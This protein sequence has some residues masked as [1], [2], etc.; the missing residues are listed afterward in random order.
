M[1]VGRWAAL[2]ALF[3]AACDRSPQGSP[4]VAAVRVETG[5]KASCLR[6]EALDER[7]TVLSTVD[8]EPFDKEEYKVAIYQGELPHQIG[9][10]ALAMWGEGCAEPLLSNGSSTT[11]RSTFPVGDP[12]TVTLTLAAP[13]ATFDVDRDGFISAGAGGPDC[14]DQSS[15]V[16]PSVREYC[17]GVT[18]LNCDGKA[19]CADPTCQNQPCVQPASQ[20]AFATTAQTVAAGACSNEVAVE[21]RDPSGTVTPVTAVT[22][23]ALS[24]PGGFTFYSDPSCAF[25]TTSV[26]LPLNGSRAVFRFRATVPGT[27]PLTATT[28]ALGS[29]TQNATVRAGSASALAFVTPA[30]TVAA[31]ACSEALTL[32]ARD[33]SGNPSPVG[34]D[35]PLTLTANPP[36]GV[37]FFADATCGL[38]AA[39]LAIPAG[40]TRATFHFR[41]TTPGAV[42]VASS[43]AGL[44]TV[45]QVQ[46]VT[47]GAPAAIV[48]V[49]PQRTAVS[50]A[51]SP[52]VTVETRDLV[53]NVAPV[54]ANTSIALSAT[55]TGSFS[56][57][58]DAA[59]TVGIAAVTLSAGQSQGSFHFRATT[60]G[61]GNL[62]TSA[63]GLTGATQP[64]TILPG[65]PAKIGFATPSQGVQSN[66]C[67]GVVTIEAQDAA[68][69]RSNLATGSMVALS[70][71]PST[72]FAFFTDPGCTTP[73]MNVTILAGAASVNFYFRGFNTGP[74]NV[75][76]QTV[77]LGFATQQH[78]IVLGPPTRLAFV[79]GPKTLVAGACS[80]V[81]S[82]QTQDA[83]GNP[84][85]V[86]AP[87]PLTLGASPAA[88]FGFF[89]DASCTT[90][91]TGITLSSG[92][93]SA[94]FYVRGTQPGA[95]GVTVSG[96]GLS[97]A[98]QTETIQAG[99]PVALV[100]ATPSQTV[101][102]GNCSG[103]AT[104]R[105]TDAFNNP[106]PVTTSTSVALT[107]T[108]ASGFAFF[109]DAGCTAP[110]SSVTLGVGTSS[111]SFYFRGTTAGSVNITAS[112][113][114]GS[115]SQLETVAAGNAAAL[116]FTTAAQTLSAGTCSGNVT[117]QRQDS[118][119]N[120]TT[121]GGTLTVSLLAAP[122]AGFTF[123]RNGSCSDGPFTSVT[124]NAGSTGTSFRFLGNVAGSVT[125]TA[126]ASGLSN[127]A[128]AETITPAPP[129]VLAF[130]SAPQTVTAGRCSSASNLESRDGF[131]NVSAVTAATSVTLLASPS[132]GFTFYSDPSCLT[133]T[134]TTTI[135]ASTSSASFWFMGTL[136][137]SVTV[138]ASASGMSSAVQTQTLSSAAQRLAFLTAAQSRAA[139]ECSA[140]VQIES[141]DMGGSPAPVGSATTV[142][143][144]AAPAT[145]F[146]FYSDAGCTTPV[147][148]VSIPAL[149]TQASF[150]FKGLTGG[151]FGVTASATGLTSAN[152][153]ETIRNAVNAGSCFIAA[154]A[155]SVSCTVS[156]AL[157][158]V[159]K[160]IV[161]FQAA[162]DGT[163]PGASYVRCHLQDAS[164]LA[165][166]RRSSF[167]TL[168]ISIDWQAAYFPTGVRVQHLQQN[169]A[170][171][172]TNV[173]L[174][175]AVNMSET[176]VLF[177]A[178]AG[179]VTANN[180]DFNTV[181]L[182]SPTNVEITH[183]GGGCTF[184]AVY[185]L[186]VVEWTGAS[187]TRGLI[188]PSPPAIQNNALTASATGLS[189]ADP[190][191]T[192]LLYSWRT[193]AGGDET[194]ERM[195]QGS[196]PSGTTLSFER[197]CSS[198][199]IDA[200]AYERVGLPNF[201]LVQQVA[202]QISS[203]LSNTASLS[204]VDTTRSVVFA[205]GMVTGGTAAGKGTHS[206]APE[207]LGPMLGRHL[208]T[209]ATTLR[210]ERG[211]GS[212]TSDWASYV[213]ELFP[214]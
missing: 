176:F 106:S 197:G 83:G 184:T 192:F 63:P 88:N 52:V 54:T 127:A 108:A 180:E 55:P 206:G 50:G 140:V 110:V 212:G 165:C 91:V 203:G 67:S 179:G 49:T 81:L 45:S 128:Q 44:G 121:L 123:H 213:V 10:R 136:P 138:T 124:I 191:R 193:G 115:A 150:Y 161:F 100:F 130:T 185:N 208:L 28:A 151:S 34:A 142:N 194:C 146:A 174:P 148:N 65:P 116:V 211:F 82:V 71:N 144:V 145:N 35:A 163:G 16:N 132:A 157:P 48:F 160:T 93:A 7:G 36:G 30:R 147:T 70:A 72:N 1:T 112:S 17:Q 43:V 94:G 25:P 85:N 9:I 209:N 202:V 95:V 182:T 175:S 66:V 111:V 125:V 167:G 99:P 3:V 39:G 77:A 38:P 12:V 51:C 149:G 118:F 32:E 131:G 8:F 96:G 199:Q 6:V 89:S 26:N 177:S 62:A 214:P 183:A 119:G 126:S 187:V 74:V 5:V 164:T 210:V 133:S 117:V 58:L 168:A 159:N 4:I 105:S 40:Q 41:A 84:S 104:V 155:A 158:D 76:A 172:T 166:S 59:C 156:P 195:L 57:F 152:Q 129:T 47:T 86:A 2:T 196:V 154:G 162:G 198:D 171:D 101:A 122:S 188:G 19:G 97:P 75:T 90:S 141:Q 24:A 14:D 169:C 102:A 87:T 200:I 201:N 21:S 207:R 135:A 27:H 204:T 56:F 107:S 205:G 114:V 103:I 120:P 22:P 79:T 53:N 80:T 68:G 143:L 113:T 92:S 170:G 134:L 29:A 33:S 189:A 109:A 23:V 46:T 42:E 78:T 64:V 11:Q 186:Q 13:D 15:Q 73:T 31:G 153:T 37:S 20:I 173:T 137:G 190:T 61:A 98:N 181:Q 178:E 69:N 18:D 60:A 139:G